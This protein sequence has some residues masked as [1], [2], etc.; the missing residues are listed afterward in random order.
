MFSTR[1]SDVFDF[2]CEEN[3]RKWKNLLINSLQQVIHYFI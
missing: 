3:C 1:D 2:E